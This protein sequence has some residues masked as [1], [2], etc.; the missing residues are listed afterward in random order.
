MTKKGRIPCKAASMVYPKK[1]GPTGKASDPIRSAP[2]PTKPPQ[3]GPTT[4]EA[5]IIGM[6]PKPIRIKLAPGK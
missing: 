2:A 4:K 3:I 6:E 5:M 1:Y